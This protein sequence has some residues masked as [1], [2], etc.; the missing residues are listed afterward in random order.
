[1]SLNRNTKEIT[2]A[3]AAVAL[4][5]IFLLLASV[6]PSGQVGFVAATSLC[7]L[8]AVSKGGVKNAVIIYLITSVL[9]FLILPE[10]AILAL[11]ILFFGYYPILKIVSEKLPKAVGWA[12][13]MLTLNVALFIIKTVF[14]RLFFSFDMFSGQIWLYYVFCTA[15]FV[16]FDIGVSKVYDYL[17]YLAHKF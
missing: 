6:L 13:K 17:K 7:S 15:V 14:S 10:K 8:F 3:A 2:S 16:V 5:V 12:F 4:S 9:G 1:M 11:Y